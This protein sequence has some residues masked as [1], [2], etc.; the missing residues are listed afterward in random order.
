MKR[1]RWQA[2]R[3]SF[4]FLQLLWP[5][6]ASTLGTQRN[7][8][9]HETLSST[10]HLDICLCKIIITHVKATGRWLF[11]KLL[12]YIQSTA[13]TVPKPQRFNNINIISCSLNSHLGIPQMLLL[14]YHEN[15]CRRLGKSLWLVPDFTFYSSRGRPVL[16]SSLLWTVLKWSLICM[17]SAEL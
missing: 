6:A 13:L 7:L 1:L 17:L 10:E 15:L 8:H 3:F 5:I 12:N 4:N 16:I 2:I 14:R 9:I 11:F